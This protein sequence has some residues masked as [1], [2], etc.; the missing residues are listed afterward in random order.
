MTQ[1]DPD[2][3][4]I[5][6]ACQHIF[7]GANSQVRKL[8][9]VKALIK[10][11]E[12][13]LTD[14]LREH[15]IN[16]TSTVAKKL[17]EKEVFDSTLKAKIRF[18]ELFD[19]SPTQSAEREASEEE[20]ARDEAS[21]VREISDREASKETAIIPHTE[22]NGE[23]RLG[24]SHLMPA[25]VPEKGT[26][27]ALG[28][29]S[30]YPVYI[31]YRCQHLVLTTIQELLEESCFAFAQQHLPQLLT[32]KGWDC[33]E[34]VELTEWTKILSCQST[35]LASALKA[36]LSDFIGLLRELRH[37]AVHRLR[38]TAA[39]V[40][41]LAENAQLFLEALE[42]L[43]RSEKVGSLRRELRSAI[44]ELQR[45]KNLLEK[46][47]LDQLKEI[48]RRRSELDVWEKNAKEAM[49]R[50]DLECSRDIGEGLE[51]IVRRSRLKDQMG[52]D[53][54]KLPDVYSESLD[55]EEEFLDATL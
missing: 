49:I 14:I 38:K 17:L 10:Q 39:G 25:I 5:Y 36:P 50:D 51:T 29:Q 27:S 20:A 15:D 54:R 35:P 24:D 6:L 37:S 12:I 18:P 52:A 4:L 26:G 23:G 11:H 42:D 9:T 13:A 46:R 41:R 45:N 33:P 44:E 22:S 30:L 31:H 21:T 53:E 1:C 47:L 40:E 43:T 2:E 32:R 19:V 55:S 34:A 8:K 3:R 48:K 16:R 28:V 7:R